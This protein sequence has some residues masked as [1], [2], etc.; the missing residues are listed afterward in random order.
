MTAKID[1]KPEHLKLLLG[2][3]RQHLPHVEIWAYGSR[4]KGTARPSSDLDLVAFA[5]PEQAAQ[6]A[7]LK[8]ELEESNLPFRVDLFL[9]DEVPET[10]KTNIE[11]GHVILTE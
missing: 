2:L 3:L 8:E 6:V 1:L 11:Q 5:Q 7:R 9:W 4:V 10:F